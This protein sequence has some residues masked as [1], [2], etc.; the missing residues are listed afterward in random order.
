MLNSFAIKTLHLLRFGSVAIVLIYAA[1]CA[2]QNRPLQ[3]LGGEGPIYPEAAQREGVEGEV[4]VVYDVDTDGR[5]VNARV[6]SSNP[7]GVFDNAAL[8]AVRSWRFNAMIVEGSPR[9]ARSRQS[10][11]TFALDAAEQY[12]QY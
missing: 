12:N 5:V 1:G 11:V 3:L 7:P 4:V 8:A 6:I 9:V 2:S 10:T